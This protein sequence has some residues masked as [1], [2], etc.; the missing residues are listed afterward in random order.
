MK[1]HDVDK[2]GYITWSEYKKATYGFM[3]NGTVDFYK[4][5]I[6]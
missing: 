4:L 1:L 6:E 3:E 2:S 5:I